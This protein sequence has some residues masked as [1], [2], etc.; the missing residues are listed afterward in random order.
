M[1]AQKLMEIVKCPAVRG[2]ECAELDVLLHEE[3]RVLHMHA[4]SCDV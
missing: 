3:V 1:L 4:G 2:Q